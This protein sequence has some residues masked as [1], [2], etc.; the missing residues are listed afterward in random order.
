MYKIAIIGGTGV[1]DPEILDD[2]KDLTVE[3]EYGT[4]RMKG[5]VYEGVP[6]A[7]MARHGEGHSVPPH[8]VNYRANIMALKKLGVERIIATAAVGSLNFDLK[9]GS[10]VVV[11]QFMDF[12]KGRPSTFFEGGD[13]GVAHVDVTEPYC[14]E[15]RAALYASGRNLGIDIFD[16][17][18]YICTEGP[19]FET[20]AEI[21]F[22]KSIGGDVV[23][24]TTVPE[25]VL[26]REVGIC[27]ATIAMVTNFG[28]GIVT[29]RL[30]H[31]EVVDYM[32]ENIVRI[33][34]LII[35]AVARIPAKKACECGAI[36]T[37]M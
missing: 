1:Y 9:P 2:V 37:Q 19:R 7:F 23:G 26:A 31:Q 29:G 12:T 34:K 8:L 5:G 21:K 14:P 30:T 32:K 15:I 36:L 4:V 28:A 17:G 6:V 24:M 18:N 20:P 33:R 10:F 22:F 11:D 13:K 3:T 25:V 16:G 27:Y 35:Q